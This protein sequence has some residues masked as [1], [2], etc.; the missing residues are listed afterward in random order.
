M[1]SKKLLNEVNWPM[2]SFSIWKLSKADSSTLRVHFSARPTLPPVDLPF[3]K[4]NIY[5]ELIHTVN[6]VKLCPECVES[7][8]HKG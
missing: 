4:C 6:R 5:K 1:F 3:N 8:K 2:A 7:I